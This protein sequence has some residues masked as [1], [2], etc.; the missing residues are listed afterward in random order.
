[1]NLYIWKGDGVLTDYTDGMIV[2]L[3]S[4]LDEANKAIQTKCSYAVDSYNPDEPTEVINLQNPYHT[5]KAWI[6]WGGG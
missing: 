2:A 1:M 5:P 6:C 3:A 4:N